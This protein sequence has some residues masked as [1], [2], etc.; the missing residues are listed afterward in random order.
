MKKAQKVENAQAAPVTPE[1]PTAAV[2]VEVLNGGKPLE[3]K[4]PD[5]KLSSAQL[6]QA[7]FL[8]DACGPVVEAVREAN[9]LE[10]QLG[11][12]YFAICRALR[13]EYK[14]IINADARKLDRKEVTLLLTS[15]GYRK[16]RITEINRVVEVSDEIW[17]SY[18][19]RKLSFRGTLQLARGSEDEAGGSGEGAGEGEKG[20]DAGKPQPKM[21]KN[22]QNDLCEILVKYFDALKSTKG[23]KPYLLEYT[24]P[25]ADGNEEK[26]FE[27]SIKVTVQ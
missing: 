20:A 21:G 13:A 1:L 5:T 11:D 24:T 22:V 7:K 19:A 12:K 17:K 27:V 10:A 3:L 2:S 23:K 25:N 26:R 18:E 8:Q 4:T 6:A 15:L 14:V 9:Q 16:Q